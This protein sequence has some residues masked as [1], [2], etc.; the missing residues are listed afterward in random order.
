MP[1]SITP[2]RPG[3][4]RMN[5]HLPLICRR[6]NSSDEDESERPVWPPRRTHLKFDDGN[7]EQEEDTEL[8]PP[9]RRIKARRHANLF[10]DAETDV[11]GDASGDEGSNDKNAELD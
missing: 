10:I 4:S 3:P 6:V 2:Q 9:R 1:A 8:E 7:Y 11:D 5:A